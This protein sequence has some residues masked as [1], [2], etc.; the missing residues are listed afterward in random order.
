MKRDFVKVYVDS[1][2][3]AQQT[4]DAFGRYKAMA[5]DLPDKEVGRLR[6]R[7]ESLS[8]ASSDY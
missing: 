4:V 1:Q 8:Q 6:R 2:A 3:L 5:A 7:A